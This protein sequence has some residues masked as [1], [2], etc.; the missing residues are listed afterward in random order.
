VVLVTTSAP[1]IDARKHVAAARAA[2][3]AQLDEWEA[4]E[5]DDVPGG[6]H[7]A[8]E[9]LRAEPLPAIYALVSVERRYVPPIRA[10]ARSGRSG[11]RLSVRAVGTTAD[12]C[13][14]ALWQ[15]TTALDEA[16]LTIDG[17]QSS[18]L[19][20]ESST[21]ALPDEGRYSALSMFTYAL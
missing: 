3:T 18:R 17:H 16:V 11:W 10:G 14:W 20:H 19:Q 1:A 2:V 7:T 12:E 9:T 5:Y 13:R 8:D 21:D 15:A 6:E 4:Y